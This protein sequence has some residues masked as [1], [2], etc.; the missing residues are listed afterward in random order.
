MSEL[1]FFLSNYGVGDVITVLIV[2]LLLCVAIMRAAGFIWE[3][4]KQHFDI[5]NDKDR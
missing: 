2:A 5:A 3:K 1:N 4:I